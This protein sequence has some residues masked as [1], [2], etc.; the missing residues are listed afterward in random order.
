MIYEN[1]FSPVG[2]SLFM[3]RE[4]PRLRSEWVFFGARIG[5]EYEKNQVECGGRAY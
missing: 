1:Q 3:G 4:F 2:M 5:D